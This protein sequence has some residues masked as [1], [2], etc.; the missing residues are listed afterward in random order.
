[1]LHVQTPI[2]YYDD[3][4]PGLRHEHD[5]LSKDDVA[6]DHKRAIQV[7]KQSLDAMM[8]SSHGT[9]L[10]RFAAVDIAPAGG[11]MRRGRSG[12]RRD[13]ILRKLVRS[14]VRFSAFRPAAAAAAAAA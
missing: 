6:A 11:E 13:P 3:G 8:H 12:C 1:M 14:Y 5:A 9:M 7:P 4:S 2:G 10:L